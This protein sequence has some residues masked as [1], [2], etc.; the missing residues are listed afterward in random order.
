VTLQQSTQYS[1]S[2]SPHDRQNAREVSLRSLKPKFLND[3][4]RIGARSDGGYVLNQ[5]SVQQSQYLLSFGINDEWSFEA[6]FLERKP[7]IKVFCFDHSVSKAIFKARMQHSLHDIFS[8]KLAAHILSLKRAR[9]RQASATAHADANARA[10][11]VLNA[12]GPA[13]DGLHEASQA[14]RARSRAWRTR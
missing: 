13:H 2:I 3:L 7:Q 14:P 10:V 1:Q 12:Q 9:V 5:A 8:P 4:T 11:V 6:E